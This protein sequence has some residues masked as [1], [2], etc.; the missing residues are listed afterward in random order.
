MNLTAR[1]F[2]VLLGT[3]LLAD[4]AYSADIRIEPAEDMILREA[5]SWCGRSNWPGRATGCYCPA[6]PIGAV[7]P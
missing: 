6:E 7:S 2:A 5:A 1:T 3:T 4:M